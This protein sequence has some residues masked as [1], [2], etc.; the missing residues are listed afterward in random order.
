MPKADGRRGVALRWASRIAVVAGGGLFGWLIVPAPA[1]VVCGLGTGCIAVGV[2]SLLADVVEAAAS[3]RPPVRVHLDQDAFGRLVRGQVVGHPGG[4]RIVLRDVSH[5]VM[6]A[7]VQRAAKAADDNRRA[8]E[9]AVMG[10]IWHET[11]VIDGRE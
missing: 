3:E 6:A 2:L 7:E 1:G 11:K 10:A 4:I 8:A 9:A 5:A